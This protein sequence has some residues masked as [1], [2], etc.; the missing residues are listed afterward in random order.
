MSA[1]T[2][3]FVVLLVVC[4]LL[5]VAADVVFVNRVE[6]YKT[7]YTTEQNNTKLVNA[8][9]ENVRADRDAARAEI[10][11]QAAERNAMKSALDDKLAAAD[12]QN[13]QLNASIAGLNSQ[14]GVK[15]AQITS[16]NETIKSADGAGKRGEGNRSVAG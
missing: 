16:L 11:A 5:L 2:K 7:K 10:L 15:D 4:S 12:A 6:D 13:K 3:L 14:L 9:L 1:L 8:N